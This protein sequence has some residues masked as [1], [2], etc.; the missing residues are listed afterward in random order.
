MKKK[1]SW[2]RLGRSLLT[3]ALAL[4]LVTAELAPALAVTQADIDKLNNEAADLKTQKK[5]LQKQ[6]DGLANDKAAVLSRQKK[7]D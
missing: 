7:L 2:R 3:L 5:D 1:H 4:C 6:L